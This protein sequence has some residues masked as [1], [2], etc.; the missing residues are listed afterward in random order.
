[1]TIAIDTLSD[2]LIDR[3]NIT[4]FTL[5][6]LVIVIGILSLIF[7]FSR[8]LLTTNRKSNIQIQECVEYIQG[9]L[10]K[11][12]YN[13]IYNK[14]ITKNGIKFFADNFFIYSRTNDN[15]IELGYE[16]TTVQNIQLGIDGTIYQCNTSSHY[17]QL[18]WNNQ[19]ITIH[20]N[21]REQNNTIQIGENN[22]SKT[23]I[24]LVL[25]DKSPEA[26]CQ[27]YSNIYIDKRSQNLYSSQQK[28]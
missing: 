5:I 10:E 26:N 22:Q 24:E 20:K 8:N 27:T 17:I 13:A 4:W 15:I 18:S 6:E 1:M 3:K 12:W 2:Q 25:C 23:S 21:N 9:S 28:N 19:K 7:L 16:D 11:H 14:A